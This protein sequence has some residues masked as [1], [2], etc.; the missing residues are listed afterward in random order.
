[1]TGSLVRA[2]IPAWFEDAMQVQADGPQA[3]EQQAPCTK[4][5]TICKMHHSNEDGMRT[6]QRFPPAAPGLCMSL[7]P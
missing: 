3:P 4:G 5:A 2:I 7:L 1:M 6:W